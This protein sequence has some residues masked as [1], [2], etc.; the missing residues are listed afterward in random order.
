VL[1][2]A[3]FENTHIPCVCVTEIIVGYGLCRG[4]C[5]V[6][7]IAAH[8]CKFSLCRSRCKLSD[9]LQSVGES[10]G[11]RLFQSCCIL[12]MANWVIF[13]SLL[14]LM[15]LKDMGVNEVLLSGSCVCTCL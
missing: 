2:V 12:E 9:S 14:L 1:L 3:F 8:V 4:A 6:N 13:N 11:L 15:G 5:D 10:L 7:H